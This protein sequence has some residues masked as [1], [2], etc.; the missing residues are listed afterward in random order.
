MGKREREKYVKWEE[1]GKEEREL[2]FTEYCTTFL[3]I[4]TLLALSDNWSI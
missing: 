4:N 1:K 3:Y 2:T